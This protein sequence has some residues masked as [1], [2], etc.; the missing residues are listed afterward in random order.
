MDV[1][2]YAQYMLTNCWQAKYTL[3]KFPIGRVSGM[4]PSQAG[5]AQ[6]RA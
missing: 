6:L 4:E 5:E 3:L 1:L 2:N